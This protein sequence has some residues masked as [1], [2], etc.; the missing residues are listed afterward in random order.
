L[1]DVNKS[2]SLSP[3]EQ[4]SIWE[5]KIERIQPY[6]AFC[7][8]GPVIGKKSQVQG[9]YERQ[10]RR[11]WK[12]L[13]HISQISA[14]RVEKV[15]DVIHIDERVWV[16]VLEVERQDV[17]SFN[18]KKH[19]NA[20]KSE[21]RYRIK[22]SMKDVAQ[23]G[24]KLDLKWK[25]EAKKQVVSQLETKLNSM[26]GMGVARD[27][28][29]RLVLKVGGRDG[30]M[31]SKKTIFRGGYTLVD[32]NEG[33]PE[34]IQS[35]AVPDTMNSQYR[36]AP[37][38]RG[39]GATLPAWMTHTEG[40]VRTSSD[41]KKVEELTQKDSHHL[42]VRKDL[43]QDHSR[44]G[45]SSRKRS[46]SKSERKKDRKQRSKKKKRHEHRDRH[47]HRDLGKCD[48]NSSEASNSGSSQSYKV[49]PRRRK[50]HKSRSHRRDDVR[51]EHLA[52][53]KR[54]EDKK[55]RK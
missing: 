28:M 31:A 32:D 53:S 43:F 15:E 4:G 21:S 1:I 16:K 40:P 29:E 33:E 45:G 25:N 37:L 20:T 38:G 13:V 14:T 11:A 10:Q 52:F 44:S 54:T 36:T 18:H 26:I 49:K 55:E 51:E 27:P 30:N 2:P 19:I 42:K 35:V 8:F 6:G 5:G 41:S 39:R 7:S 17:D 23:D 46:S 24:T 34:S 50:H 3:P 12:G 47:R 9:K 48:I 22:L